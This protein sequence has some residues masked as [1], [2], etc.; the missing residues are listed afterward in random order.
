MKKQVCILLLI[1]L[2]PIHV[3]A[4]ISGRDSN[5]RILYVNAATGSDKNEGSRTAPF[6]TINRAA[7]EAMPGNTVLVAPG[8]YREHVKPLRGGT[9]EGSRITYR[10]D[11]NHGEVVIKA[12][13]QI[14]TEHNGRT[15]SWTQCS[16][17]DSG[18]VWRAVIPDSFFE[19]PDKGGRG[20]GGW[21]N[22]TNN[23]APNHYNPFRQVHWLGGNGG[24]SDWTAGDVYLN[25]YAYSQKFTIGDVQEAP[26]SWFYDYSESDRET[27][28]YVNFGAVNPN[29]P[30]NLVEINARRQNFAPDVFGLQYITVDGFT[31]MHAGNWFSDFPSQPERA[32]RGSISVFGGKRWIIEN[33]SIINA[34]SI[35]IDIGLG[36][37]TWGGSR[38]DANKPLVRQWVSSGDGDKYGHHIIRHNYIAKCGQS[39]IAGVHSWK[40]EILYNHI[41]ETNY[42]REFEGSETGA[43]KVHFMN[44]GLIEGNY[45]HTVYTRNGGG[46]WGDWGCDGLRVTRNIVVNSHWPFYA[47]ALHGP[48]LVDNNIFMG[49]NE[50]RTLDASGVVF[51]NNMYIRTDAN[52]AIAATGNA[53][54]IVGQG[55]QCSWY[56]PGTV[57]VGGRVRQ[58]RQD[59]WWYNNITSHI[60]P[61][62]STG[63]YQV[64]HNYENTSD[65]AMSNISYTAGVESN[66]VSVKFNFNPEAT[67]LSGHMPVIRE[68]VPMIIYPTSF[69]PIVFGDIGEKIPCDVSHDFFGNEYVAGARVSGPFAKVQSGANEFVLWPIPGHKTPPPVVIKV[70]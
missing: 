15:I 41:V 33:N 8:L 9:S 7:Q 23:Q 49:Y 67:G 45:I 53:I 5:M 59:F 28:V 25:N 42:R 37:D 27:S 18:V 68:T 29:D 57:Q 50:M 63:S 11:G 43:I 65:A 10:A 24:S 19:E 47:E 3:Q 35:G 17:G 13:E 70:P 60:L 14:P 34:R 46:I 36:C 52:G 6:K 44:Y 39:G 20:S 69:D 16:A 48:V 26:N 32:Q 58:P 55:R 64:V 12:S 30:Q 56:L 61:S 51:V 22:G 2:L 40:S 21:T 38:N 1:G 54:S 4:Q 66:E 62:N 31:M